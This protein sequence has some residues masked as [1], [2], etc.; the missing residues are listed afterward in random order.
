MPRQA[1]QVNLCRRSFP[2]SLADTSIIYY[3]EELRAS[4][5][6]THEM[7]MTTGGFR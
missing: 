5:T 1:R 3:F 4:E 7:V 2:S 6:V